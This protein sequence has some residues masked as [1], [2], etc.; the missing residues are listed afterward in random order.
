VRGD[1]AILG[2]TYFDVLDKDGDGTGGLDELKTIMRD[3]Q[4]PQKAAYTFF[5]ATDVDKNGRQECEEMHNLFHK[6]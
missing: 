3:F 2:N 1:I 4:A 5:D 6:F